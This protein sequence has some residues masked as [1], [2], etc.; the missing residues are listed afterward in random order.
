[1][2]NN[3]EEA[4]NN[5]EEDKNAVEGDLINQYNQLEKEN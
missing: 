1:M 4:Y 2:S 5:L 3:H